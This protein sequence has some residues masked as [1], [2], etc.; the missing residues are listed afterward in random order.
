MNFMNQCSLHM[1]TGIPTCDVCKHHLLVSPLVIGGPNL[2]VQVDETCF[3]KRKVG[4]EFYQICGY[5]TQFVVKHE[6]V[7]LLS[8]RDRFAG[9]SVL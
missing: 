4:E 8:V 1:L 2:Y 6:N 9:S 5:L 7:F 3:R